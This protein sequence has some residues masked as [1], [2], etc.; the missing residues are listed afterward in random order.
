MGEMTYGMLGDD[1]QS[2]EDKL[3]K[4]TG[5]VNWEY[6]KASYLNEALYF[7][8]ASLRLEEVGKAF[9][10]DQTLQVQAWIKTGELTKI[11]ELHAQWFEKE[12]PTFQALVVSPFVLCQLVE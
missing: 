7:V 2:H 5:E 4:Y 10:E 6:L 9:S 12:D 8:N 3:A 1:D 11:E